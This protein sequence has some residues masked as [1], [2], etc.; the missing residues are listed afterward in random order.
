MD[1]YSHPL[2]PIFSPKMVAV[3]G[4][5]ERPGSVG[6][7]ILWNLISS[8]F[9]GTVFPVNPSRSNVLGIK[10]YPK[11]ADISEKIDLAVIV[12][13]AESVPKIVTECADV[14]VKGA[15]IISA[16]F[17][18]TGESGIRLEQEILDRAR[19]SK[20]RIIGPNCL[21]IM[22]PIT[23]LNATFARSMAKP[24]NV[25]FI[26]QSGALCTAVLDWSFQANVGFSSFISI[27]SMLDVSWGDLIDYLGDDA[28]TQ[29]IVIYMESIGDARSFL[30]AAREVALTKPI[31]VL[32]AGRTERSAKATTSHTGT[33]A[34]SDDVLDAAFQRCGVLRVNT[35][36]E[37]FYMAQ[38][39]SK[40]PRPRGPRLSVITNAGGPGVLAADALIKNG[41]E[42]ATLSKDTLT[43]LNEFLSP[44]WSHN[45]PIDILGDANPNSY[46]KA[47]DIVSKDHNTDGLLVILTPQAVTDPTQTAEQLKSFGRNEDIPI[48]ASWMGGADVL[49]GISILNSA[50]IPTFPYP[51]LAVRAF[52]FMWR[53]SFNLRGLYETPEFS[54]LPD[55]EPIKLQSVK[56]LLDKVNSSARTQLTE[57]E[58]KNLFECYGIPV[59]DTR[60]AK[61]CEEAIAIAEEIGYPVVLKLNSETI[62]HKSDVDGVK[63]DLLDA[64]AI[65]QA[66]FSIQSS[67]RNKVNIDAFQGVTVQPM[68]KTDGFEVIVGS[69]VDSQFGP[70]LLFGAGGYLVETFKDQALSLPPLTTTLARRMIEKTQIYKALQGVRGKKPV[71]ILAL[72]KLLVRFSQLVSEQPKIKEI[73]INP[74]LV[75]TDQILALDARIILHDSK[76]SSEQSSRC[77]IRPYPKQY[78]SPWAL[79][80][81]TDVVIRPIRPED[82]PLIVKFHEPLSEQS[83][84]FY[85]FQPMKLS[86]RTTHERLTRICFLDYDRQI[87]LVA[88]YKDH[89]T[90]ERSILGVVRLIKQHGQ[91][92]AEFAMIVGD[93]NQKKG[94]GEE[95]LRRLLQIARDEKLKR[96]TADILPDNRPM[97][98]ICEKL[99]FKLK[100]S[101]D[102]P[103]LKAYIDF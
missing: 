95:L 3:I 71:N 38:V 32:K 58:S 53:Y 8:S 90:A 4:A 62:S 21:G 80:D 35:I 68:I 85:F 47:V 37:L 57:L 102:N 45:N 61:S 75:S 81:G 34:G 59:V 82:E 39:L 60:L 86:R 24:G 44:N 14:G 11:I 76:S 63:L 51:D 87:S 56:G 9:G 98:R 1:Y 55:E 74:L 64:H 103:E 54:L 23:G 30:S 12:T 89:T 10:S 20:M 29:S 48:L 88:E 46:A 52:I 13:P 49:A 41:G 100:R 50:N 78:V 27:G 42:L 5:T 93:S 31:I 69:S 79:R 36:D 6:R 7:N 101:L 22:C 25:G 72:E 97:Q 77:A 94:L 70:V 15:I 66:F 91:K 26:S 73:D 40:Q 2:Y 28:K 99:G 16:G 83:V 18:E 96:I 84:Y 67:V 33:L 92:E 17:K 19:Q 65:G 43:G